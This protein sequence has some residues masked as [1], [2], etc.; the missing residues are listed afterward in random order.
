MDFNFDMF[1][2]PSSQVDNIQIHSQSQTQNVNNNFN[3]NPIQNQ[4]AS[5]QDNIGSNKNNDPFFKF[6]HKDP[7]E[8]LKMSKNIDNLFNLVSPPPLSTAK[9]NQEKKMDL[10]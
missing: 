8:S 7:F 1:E 5:Y 10:F 2:T 4:I 3:V 9:I 6:E